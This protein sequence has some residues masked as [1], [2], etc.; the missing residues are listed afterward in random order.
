MIRSNEMTQDLQEWRCTSCGFKN[1]GANRV[2]GGTGSLGCKGPK[3]QSNTLPS[4]VY[5]IS[6]S[7]IVSSGQGPWTCLSC[8]FKNVASNRKCGGH[9]NLGCNALRP[10]TAVASPQ[11][12]FGILAPICPSVDI[13]TPSKPHHTYSDGRWRCGSCGFNNAESND[14]CGGNGRLGCKAAK[15]Q[16][17][18]ISSV[19]SIVSIPKV[20][21]INSINDLYPPLDSDSTKKDSKTDPQ[22]WVCAC[23]FKNKAQNDQC[24][25]RGPLGCNANR[26]EPWSCICGFR[27]RGDND[28]CGGN[29]PM[30]CDRPKPSVNDQLPQIIYSPSTFGTYHGISSIYSAPL[31]PVSLPVES[32]STD[33]WTC[34]E[35]G[36]RNSANNLVCGGRGNLG[37]K[38]SREM[39][40]AD[41]VC[42]G[43]GKLGC[44]A[45][46]PSKKLKV[47]SKRKRDDSVLQKS[48]KR[49][50][51][52][53][54]SRSSP[55]YVG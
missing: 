1:K 53:S 35:C 52:H 18:S 10:L 46:L 22:A 8:G 2:C 50:R 48:S 49:S 25:G 41:T 16:P 29:G 51:Y 31:V 11:A 39:S 4:V 42:G 44:K 30:G 40:S 32:S 26:P 55:I 6:A 20:D 7:P 15:D 28:K 14:I 37:C 54:S 19:P 43:M 13:A 24:G 38:A 34:T 17:K 12:S 3:T 27:N 9:G 47:G 33:K 45:P 36:F 5:N 23:G 21:N